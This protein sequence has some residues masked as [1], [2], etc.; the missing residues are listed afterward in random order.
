[1]I[2]T[3]TC[4]NR[5]LPDLM[6]SQQKVYFFAMHLLFNIFISFIIVNGLNKQV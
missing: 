4:L 3:G 5:S 2:V 1:M 6:S